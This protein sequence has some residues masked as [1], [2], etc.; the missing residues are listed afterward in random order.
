MTFAD[1][2]ECKDLRDDDFM[3]VTQ[4][5]LGVAVI[6]SRNDGSTAS[7]G[8]NLRTTTL[9]KCLRTNTSQKLLYRNVNFSA[10]SRRM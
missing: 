8:L 2:R 5:T 7:F 6:Q 10:R 3:V 4:A 9:Q 1:F